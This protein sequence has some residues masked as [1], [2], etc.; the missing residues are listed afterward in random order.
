MKKFLTV[1]FAV[2]LGVFSLSLFACDKKENN[3]EN[4][5]LTFVCPDGAPALS[6][7]K[8]INDEDDLDTDAKINYQI[9]NSDSIGGIMSK[10]SA[11]IM[12]LPVNA[13]SKL[14]KAYK[15]DSYKMV[16]VV[17][18]GNL[19]IV[20]TKQIEVS[21][22]ENE[23]LGVIGQGLVPDLTLKYVLSKNN[24]NAKNITY[25]QTAKEVL[26][27]LKVGGQNG[28]E[29][30][31]LPEP[32]LSNLINS[33]P[34][35]QFYTTN[36]GELYDSEVKAYPQAILMVKQ[37]VLQKYSN[38][39]SYLERTFDSNVTWLKEN[40]ENGVNAINSKLPD[41]V[42]PSLVANKISGEVVDRCSVYWQNSDN[43]KGQVK[44]YINNL[45]T[46][47][48]NSAKAIQDDFFYSAN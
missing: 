23:K 2:V 8:Y 16:S 12:V 24:V 34:N 7:A 35:K 20:S 30:A 28:L 21:D 37:S 40:T 5:E 33:T 4:V 15:D 36:L 25:Y 1:V 43:A 19:Y 45:I 6:I 38:L 13:A 18:H 29:T 48:E 10:G 41:G 47:N 9:V 26:P 46:I 42:T 27:L 17:T 14:Y 44:Q 22:L 39:V 31:L 32:A 11:D 3:E